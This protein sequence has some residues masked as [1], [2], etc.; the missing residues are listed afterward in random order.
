MGKYADNPPLRTEDQKSLNRYLN[1]IVA[2]MGKV[3][4]SMVGEQRQERAFALLDA[5]SRFLGK[6]QA[7][8]A[9]KFLLRFAM[10]KT[11]IDE[12]VKA[13]AA[14]TANTDAVNTVAR[15]NT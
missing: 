12:M 14:Q 9:T 5:A 6:S 3:D 8:K 13:S 11:L 4:S 1:Q 2:A 15:P 10:S 7:I